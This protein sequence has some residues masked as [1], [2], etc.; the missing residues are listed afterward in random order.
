MASALNSAVSC[1]YLGLEENFSSK[2]FWSCFFK[3]MLIEQI[4]ENVCKNFK[5]VS[6]KF[7]QTYMQKCVTW[8]KKS[9]NYN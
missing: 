8:P 9:K 1:E 3:G 4:D 6:I 2:L 5:Y 7:A